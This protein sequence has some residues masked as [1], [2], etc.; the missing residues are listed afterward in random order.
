MVDASVEVRPIDLGS[1]KNQ[2]GIFKEPKEV[3]IDS[4]WLKT[5]PKEEI[6]S[7]FGRNVKAWFN[8]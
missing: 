1:L 2:I 4:N 8:R 7:G 5:L 3:I 6:R